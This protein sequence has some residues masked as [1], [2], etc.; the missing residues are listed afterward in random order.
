M[1]ETATC[2][3]CGWFGNRVDP[4]T[5]LELLED[6]EHGTLCSSCRVTLRLESGYYE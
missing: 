4:I 1:T 2:E 3:R 5:E 6:T